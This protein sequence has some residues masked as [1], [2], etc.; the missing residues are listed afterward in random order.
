MR[1]K[2][3]DPQGHQKLGH[4]FDNSLRYLWSL[5]EDKKD[6]YV[7]C[8]GVVTG[9]GNLEGIRYVHAWLEHVELPI[10]LDPALHK[11]NPPMFMKDKYYEVGKIE[12]VVRY[13]VKE[14]GELGAKVGH[15]GPWKEFDADA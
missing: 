2:A 5:P 6:L 3:H 13:T 4:C 15:F 1:Y 14:A 8:H 11:K 7:L 12:Q 9:K 10:V